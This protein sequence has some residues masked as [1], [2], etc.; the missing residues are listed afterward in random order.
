MEDRQKVV[1]N[2]CADS[3]LAHFW[4]FFTPIPADPQVLLMGVVP[5]VTMAA[6][7]TS[8]SAVKRAM[9]CIPAVPLVRLVMRHRLRPVT[10]AVVMVMAVEM[11]AAMVAET[12]VVMAAAMAVETAVV[13]VGAMVV[14]TAMETAM[15]TAMATRPV[16]VMARRPVTVKAAKALPCPSSTKKAARLLSLC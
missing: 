3:E 6:S 4:L 5:V 2:F 9:A 11:V 12:A 16:M 1:K 15:G 13:M 14:E 8:L 10:M 7:T